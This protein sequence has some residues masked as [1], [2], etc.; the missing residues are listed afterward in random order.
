M[1]GAIRVIFNLPALASVDEVFAEASKLL[2]SLLDQVNIGAPD[3]NLQYEPLPPA[4]MPVATRRK[5]DA[6][7]IKIL[8]SKLS[9]QENDAAVTEAVEALLQF[10][11]VLA[12]IAGVDIA[13]SNKKLLEAGEAAT[14]S[15]TDAR[16]KLSAILSALGLDEGASGE[17]INKIAQVMEQSA[18]LKEVM[19]ELETLRTEAKKAEEAQVETD[20]DEAMATKG[21]EDDDLRFALV[22]LRKSNKDDFFKRY[23]KSAK[24]AATSSSANPQLTRQ[25]ATTKKGGESP[26][27]INED[28][29]LTVL[30]PKLTKNVEGR[31]KLTGILGA[32]R[33]EK[34]IKYLQAQPGGDKM[35]HDDLWTKA[36]ELNRAGMLDDGTED[37]A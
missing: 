14:K 36:C 31:I 37:A 32:N 1:I 25:I 30:K 4:Q 33:I 26:I 19:P 16:S 21:I 13:A 17:A 24:V 11:T 5:S 8:A 34:A 3:T 10:R 22:A 20:V 15:V 28:G 29:S 6:M 35:S 23:P 18:K 27:R 2:Q 7:L 12:A 9:V